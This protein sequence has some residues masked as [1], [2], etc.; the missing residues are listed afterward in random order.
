MRP[1]VIVSA[2]A[3]NT[4]ARGLVAVVPLTGTV[5][6]HPLRVLVTPPE[7]SLLK[8]SDVLCNQI[9]TISLNRFVHHI[10][11]LSPQT[12]QQVDMGIRLFLDV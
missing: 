1:V 3:F 8:P 6:S 9:R 12:L 4:R 7:G 11:A 5:R 10:G 2:S